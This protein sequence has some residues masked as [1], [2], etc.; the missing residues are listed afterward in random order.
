MVARGK[1]VKGWTKWIVDARVQ[2]MKSPGN[3]MN[4]GNKRHSIGSTANGIV[5]MLHV[6]RRKLPLL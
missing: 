5:M 2:E 6:D 3:G 4:H 1:A